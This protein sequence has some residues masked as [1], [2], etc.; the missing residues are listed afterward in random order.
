MGLSKRGW[1]ENLLLLFSKNS[2]SKLLFM[3]LLGTLG[4]DEAEEICGLFCHPGGKHTISMILPQ[5]GASEPHSL[6]Y[7]AREAYGFQIG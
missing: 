5:L 3:W 6:K 2:I 4:P 1:K 7:Q